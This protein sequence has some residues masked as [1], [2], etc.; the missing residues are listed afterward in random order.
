VRRFGEN[1]ADGARGI[2]SPVRNGRSGAFFTYASFDDPASAAM[3][4]L[5]LAPSALLLLV[6]PDKPRGEKWPNRKAR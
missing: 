3:A 6:L 5:M 2:S 4:V 1:R